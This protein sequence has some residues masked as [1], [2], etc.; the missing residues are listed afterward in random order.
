MSNQQPLTK[1]PYS[2]KK[3]LIEFMQDFP[4]C[5]VRDIKLSQ[6]NPIPNSYFKQ[7]RSRKHTHLAL[8]IDELGNSFVLTNKGQRMQLIGGE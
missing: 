8:Q 1:C 3:V 7:L 6:D 4:T 5:Q 2:L